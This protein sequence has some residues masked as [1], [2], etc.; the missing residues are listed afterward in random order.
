MQ[1]RVLNPALINFAAFDA[2]IIEPLGQS[3]EYLADRVRESLVRSGVRVVRAPSD[4]AGPVA[5]LSL[6][7]S[8]QTR[9]VRERF[10]RPRQICDSSGCF[11]TRGRWQERP[12][13]QGT[14]RVLVSNAKTGERIHEL[15]LHS[16]WH[17]GLSVLQR[18][19]AMSDLQAQLMEALEVHSD[20]LEVP[21]E[22]VDHPEV[23][24]GTALLEAGRVE[25]ARLVLE[26]LWTEVRRLDVKTRGAYLYNLGV[27]RLF[28]DGPART[29]D[30]RFRSAERAFRAAIREGSTDKRQAALG[31]LR[32]R[33]QQARRLA[34][35]RIG[36]APHEA[37]AT[38]GTATLEPAEA[39]PPPPPSYRGEA[40]PTGP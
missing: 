36:R 4:A 10:Q 37:G 7:V 5:A 23:A 32:E 3:A 28:D 39:V 24:R 16:D 14:L 34:A 29:L 26:P 25:E 8:T 2:V 40:A 22:T 1:A 30:E 17:G 12:R 27:A 6:E 18:D 19:R 13:V 31:L 35:Q 38:T 20:Y 11:E 33:E 21:L 9:Y 15:W